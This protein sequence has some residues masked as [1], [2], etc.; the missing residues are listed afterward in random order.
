LQVHQF[1]EGHQFGALKVDALDRL[2]QKDLLSYSHDVRTLSFRIKAPS[3]FL[4]NKIDYYYNMTTLGRADYNSPFSGEWIKSEGNTINILGMVPGQHRLT[5]EA[6]GLDREAIGRPIEY[7][8]FMRQPFF[9]TWIFWAGLVGIGVLGL[10]IYFQLRTRRMRRQ[11]QILEQ[12]VKE[13]TQ[14]IL[15]GQQIIHRQA[16][17]IEQLDSLLN[18][19]DEK[20]AQE[21]EE[22]VKDNLGNFNLNI[23]D[24]AVEMNLSRTHFFRKIK[25]VTGFT[26][27]QY[28]KEAR[29]NEAKRMLESGECDT[30]KAV[31]LSV[32]FKKSSY[33]STQFKERFGYSP[34]Q[35]INP[36]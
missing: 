13:R 10:F 17:Q 1:T 3:F 14:E 24:I 26:P 6:R 28:L 34:N 22:V 25:T 35:Y 5:I 32:G 12:K 2:E 8:I 36:N 7:E 16:K 21:L 20:W 4:A 31:S 15:K 9:R 29:L 19:A 33:F 11:Q 23:A 27:N 30:V 18:K